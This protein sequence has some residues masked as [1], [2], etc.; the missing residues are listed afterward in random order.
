MT[1]PAT[2]LAVPVA[3]GELYAAQ[4]GDDPSLP[5]V[6]GLHGITASHKNF[7]LI[8]RHLAG[9]ANLV[10]PDLRGRG[11]SASLPGPYG[12]GA[13][14]DDAVAVLDHLGLGNAVFVGHS[15]GAF[16]TTTAAVRHPDRV[17][18]AVLVDGG[19]ALDVP[20]GADIDAILDAVIGPAMQ[21]LSMTF[22][23]RD[24]YHDFWRAHPAF[25][26]EG[27][28]TPDVEDYVDYDL[29]GSEPE[30]RSRALADAVRA[31][32]T[33]TLV[34]DR[35][36]N[37]VFDARCPMTLL[38]AERGLLNQNPGLYTEDVLNKVAERAPHLRV[39]FVADLNHYTIA[40]SDRGAVVVAGAI[41]DV[42]A[43]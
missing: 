2:S 15:M 33:D 5:T 35:A 38:W 31:D 24:A 4:W 22:P 40:L 28:W 3:G 13:H 10:A 17:R 1:M 7:T 12:M 34:D 37:A 19:V 20:R 8:A 6:V 27:A 14:A 36:K 41:A 30:L 32:A 42:A 39:E 16:V 25:Q 18:A 26:D 21:R 9:R 43:E 11:A 29:G 23:S